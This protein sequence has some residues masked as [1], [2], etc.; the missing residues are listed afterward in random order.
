MTRA[1]LRDAERI[2]LDDALSPRDRVKA[3]KT[4]RLR[5][6]VTDAEVEEIDFVIGDTEP[7]TIPLTAAEQEEVAI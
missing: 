7:L 4:I 6:S 5:A 3:L 1:D 2:M